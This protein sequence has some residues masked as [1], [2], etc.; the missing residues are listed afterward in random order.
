MPGVLLEASQ[1]SHEKPVVLML[2]EWDKTRPSDGFFLD[3]LQYGKLSIPGMSVQANLDN[4]LI[5]FTANDDRTF[6]EA[7]HVG[8]LK[9]ISNL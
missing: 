3:F 1:M 2:D 6:H 8:F 4:M 7:A 9:W 5:F